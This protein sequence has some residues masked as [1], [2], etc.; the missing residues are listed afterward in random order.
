MSNLSKQLLDMIKF[1]DCQSEDHFYDSGYRN[2][3][4][5]QCRHLIKYNLFPLLAK[6]KYN[7]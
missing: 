6:G 7:D 3:E 4:C 5:E 2:Y 1:E